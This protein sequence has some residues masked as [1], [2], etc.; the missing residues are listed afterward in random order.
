VI[1]FCK[2]GDASLTVKPNP[3]NQIAGNANIEGSPFLAGQDVNS[4]LFHQS[5][6]F[7]E[8]VYKGVTP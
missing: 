1:F 2:A 4:R 7:F 8:L 6:S 3:L 5:P